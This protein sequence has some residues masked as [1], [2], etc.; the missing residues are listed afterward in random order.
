MMWLEGE[1]EAEGEGRWCG[2]TIEREWR[3]WMSTTKEEDMCAS[4]DSRRA[5]GSRIGVIFYGCQ[6]S[7]KANQYDDHTTSHPHSFD[8]EI[9]SVIIQAPDPRHHGHLGSSLPQSLSPSLSLSPHPHN[10]AQHFATT[11]TGL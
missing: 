4:S 1:G 10:K 9:A 6:G 2:V 5:R 11:T 7:E 3:G 8:T